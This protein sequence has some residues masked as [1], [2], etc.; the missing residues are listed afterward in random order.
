MPYPMKNG[1][2]KAQVR[3]T[4]EDGQKHQKDKTFLT[5]KEALNWEAEM[6]KKPV[7]EWNGKTDMVCLVDWAETY[8]D[9]AQDTFVSKTYKEKKAIFRNFFT[10][11]DANLPVSELK[12]G[13]TLKYIQK[14]KNERSGHAANKDR[15]NLVA[16]WNWGMEYMEPSLPGPNPF[17]VKRMPEIRHPRY[18]PPEED[19][20]KVYD[21]VEG[22]DRVMLL[23]FLHLAARRCEV[24]RM[25]WSDIDFGH[26]RI[27][28]WTRKR[29]DG[30][31]ESD[32]LPMTQELRQSLRWWWENRPIKDRPNV[33]M[34]LNETAASK[35]YYGGLFQKRQHFMKRN[36][37]KAKVKPFGFHAIRH[38]S[39]SI[40]YNLGYEVAVIQ[41]I[42][43][44]K[45]P[46]TTEGYLKT[47]GLEGVRDAMEDL[48]QKKRKVLKFKQRKVS[49][50]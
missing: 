18:V 48:S 20:W 7:S 37:E 2:Y 14:Q 4:T 26:S 47:L 46:S 28:L 10:E 17:L 22:Q 36:C 32:W 13:T 12:K 50:I 25:D 27:R 33:F 31:F 15:K 11:V 19:F 9:Y 43:R 39:A 8:L 29:K 45:N 16:G 21:V 24:F 42:L 41:T 30:S 23:T 1:K 35:K 49:E 34:C 40:L 3:K 44:H 6:R 5:K 38:L